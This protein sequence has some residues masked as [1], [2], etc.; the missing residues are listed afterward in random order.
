M[1]ASRIALSIPEERRREIF[2][3]LVAA[4]DGGLIVSQSRRVIASE[5]GVTRKQL[6]RIEEEGIDG[7]WPP[8]GEA[9]PQSPRASETEPPQADPITADEPALVPASGPEESR[10]A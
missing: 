9:L 8:L 2:R 3:A 4:Q 6:Q 5:F 10:A 7:E 1:P